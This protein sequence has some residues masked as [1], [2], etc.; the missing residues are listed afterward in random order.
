MGLH[1]R[2]KRLAGLIL[3]CCGIIILL[4]VLL[5]FWC[6]IALAAIGLI[7]F[8]WVLFRKH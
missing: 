6:W 8:G 3:L 1:Y 4:L 5:P 7:W 2:G